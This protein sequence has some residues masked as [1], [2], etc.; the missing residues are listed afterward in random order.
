M[1]KTPPTFVESTGQT[2]RRFLATA[3]AAV[4]STVLLAGCIG[5]D[6]TEAG[7]VDAEPGGAELQRDSAV[8]WDELGDLEGTVT[9]YS[10][11]KRTQID[12]LFETIED[13]YPDL[14]IRREYGDNQLGQL[15][16]EGSATPADLYYTQSSGELAALKSEGLAKKLPTDIVEAIDENHSDPDGR[17]TGVSGRV[18]AVLYNSNAFSAAELPTD[19]FAYAEDDRFEDRIS[20]RPNSGTFRS[21]IVAMIE[22]E[23]EERTREW[24]RSM[25][26]D[27]NATLYA[28]GREQA[29]A[30]HNGERD[31]AL[32]NQYYA[33][34]I[35]QNNPDSPLAVTFT[36]ND[37]GCLFNVSGLAVTAGVEDEQLASDFI[38]HALGKEGQEFFVNTNGEYPV[39]DDVPYVGDLP[40]RAEINPPEFDLNALENVQDAQDLLRD[41]G[42]TV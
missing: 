21:F 42:M 1:A 10:D 8:S 35:I 23:G 22:L 34:R 25:V 27:Q 13:E 4:G 3:G 5:D 7:A 41:E 38:R 19:I 32:G 14:E 2:R 20:T 11:R 37:P 17:W 16:T 15:I 39:V 40:T 29:E 33:G 28:G 30:V 24:V 9:V 31:I 12:P 26:E 6:D 36:D 18:R